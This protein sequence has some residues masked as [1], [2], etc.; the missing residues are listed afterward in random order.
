MSQSPSITTSC[1]TL[2]ILKGSKRHA[3]A[4]SI[5]GL[6]LKSSK[7]TLQVSYTKIYKL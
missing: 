1:F 6:I 7:T 5:R 4:K 2:M 3:K